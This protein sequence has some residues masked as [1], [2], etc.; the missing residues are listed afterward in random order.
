MPAFVFLS[1]RFTCLKYEIN[2]VLASLSIVRMTTSVCICLATGHMKL[3]CV[4]VSMCIFFLPRK[5]GVLTQVCYLGRTSTWCLKKRSWLSLLERGLIPRHTLYLLSH[6]DCTGPSIMSIVNLLA[7]LRRLNVSFHST[8][9]WECWSWTISNL[10]Y[11]NMHIFLLK[12]RVESDSEQ[13]YVCC[14]HI[15]HD[16]Q[17]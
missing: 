2:C 14:H 11:K 4:I 13:K 7:L 15:A 12:L 9:Y 1:W 8:Q 5:S 3:K 10:G 6:S 17:I 16:D